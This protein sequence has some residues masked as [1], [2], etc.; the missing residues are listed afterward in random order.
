MSSNGGYLQLLLLPTL[1]LAS[2]CIGGR[3]PLDEPDAGQA[4]SCTA[5]SVTM[6]RARPTVMFVLDRSRS[7][8]IAI[9]AGS[10]QTRW[11]A[12]G[13]AL[14][15]V[16]PQ[17]TNAVD[18]GALLFPSAES[19]AQSC[20]VATKADLS[21]AAGNVAALTK[22]MNSTAPDGFTPTASAIDTAASVVLN[23]RAATTARA[24]VLATDGAPDCNSALD[25]RTCRC[26]NGATGRGR[27]GNAE[28]CLDDTRTVDVIS[29]YE[30][31]GLPTYVIGIQSEG[32]TSFSGVLNAMADAGG[33]PKAGGGLRYYAA[34]SEADLN[35]ALTAVR[36]LVGVCTY[37]TTSVPDPKGHIVLK[38]DGSALTPDQW[39]WS[40]LN[41]GEVTL[42]GDAC[43]AVAAEKA[44]VVV[45]EVECA[46]G[47]L[48]RSPH[49]L[50]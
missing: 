45:A 22:L 42:L 19:G 15:A 14:G 1:A 13:S 28:Q 17:V 47:S 18:L 30:A 23:V 3:T 33:R 6:T 35:A 16:L 27:C 36:D 39:T 48:R 41:N 21:P 38:V 11:Q 40:N 26:A 10:S 8:T 37:L 12:L 5:G 29:S 32:D 31:R 44:P 20:S 7:M 46:S 9:S 24:L 49:R 43:L 50:D 2:G 25:F 4:V 34:S